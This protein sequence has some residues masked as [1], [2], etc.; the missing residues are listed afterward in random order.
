MILC[1]FCRAAVGLPTG[2][3]AV[4]IESLFSDGKLLFGR[5]GS[6]EEPYELGG[7]E[8]PRVK[9]CSLEAV[10]F[11]GASLSVFL[12]E[13]ATGISRFE[14]RFL[15]QILGLETGLLFGSRTERLD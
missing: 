2:L 13:V 14:I 1:C 4:F 15:S 10:E 11:R 12:S 6:L 9:R 3:I 8:G 7:L 5:F